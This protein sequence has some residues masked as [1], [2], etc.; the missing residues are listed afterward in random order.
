MNRAYHI[1]AGVAPKHTI[2][3]E[4]KEKKI[5]FISEL[6]KRYG[7]RPVQTPTFEYY[8]LFSQVEGTIDVD[9]MIKLVDQDGKILV[10]RPDATIPI[11]RMAAQNNGNDSYYKFYYTT[12]VFRMNERYPS[13][14]SREF[15][16]T[17][18]EFFGKG[19]LE[20]DLEVI[21]LAIESLKTCGFQQITLDLGQANFY[22][23]FMNHMEIGRHELMEIEKLIEQKNEFELAQ[24]LA[25]LNIEDRFKE[26]INTFPT[27]Y[28]Q[29]DAVLK[30][31]E[32]M[33][34]NDRMRS[35]LDKLKQ[36]YQ[37]L[38]ELG[39][40]K[41]VSIDLGLINHL[42]Y[43]TGIIFHGYVQGYGKPVVVGGRYDH[44]SKQF[45]KDLPATG[46]A[47]Y[48]DALLDADRD[49]PEKQSR[50]DIYVLFEKASLKKGMAVAK[51]LRDSGFIVETEIVDHLPNEKEW[52]TN[53]NIPYIITVTLEQ[54]TLI[55]PNQQP[56]RFNTIDELFRE[57]FPLQEDKRWTM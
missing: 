48:M 21:I 14:E 57:T 15:T 35:E 31:A 3:L 10:L 53:R 56:K 16:Q 2:E 41:Y 40:E 50:T 23:E 9:Q 19:G 46:F 4:K 12:N 52:E 47:I 20:A 29:P 13:S 8:D 32:K 36:L 33:L 27:L 44:L 37:M 24:K 5:T 51:K 18:I 7:Y 55:S 26:I 42:N 28:G 39:Y 17:G 6:F 22:K 34:T 30:K 25:T 43:Y 11:A 49:I 1:P 54:V 45:G 38:E